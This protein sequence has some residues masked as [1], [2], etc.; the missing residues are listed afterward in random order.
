MKL[1]DLIRVTGIPPGQFSIQGGIGR[2]VGW[3]GNSDGAWA[4]SYARVKL[5]KPPFKDVLA[6]DQKWITRLLQEEAVAFELENDD[7]SRT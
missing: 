4:E 1:G 6:L 2:I 3:Q 5:L 7:V